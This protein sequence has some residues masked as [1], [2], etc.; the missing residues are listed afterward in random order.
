MRVARYANPEEIEQYTP[1]RLELAIS[2]VEA[3]NGGPLQGRTPIAF[4]KLR[5]AFKRDGKVVTRAFADMSV[6]ELRAAV[7]HAKDFA[8]GGGMNKLQSAPE[9]MKARP[10]MQLCVKEGP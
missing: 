6:Q 2:L 1:S 5:F 7:A 8:V 9:K 3:K 10:L 4:E